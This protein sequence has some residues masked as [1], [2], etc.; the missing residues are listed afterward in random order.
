MGHKVVI[1]GEHSEYVTLDKIE[2]FKQV[3]PTFDNNDIHFIKGAGH[4]V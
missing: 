4:W 3:F 1:C 2:T